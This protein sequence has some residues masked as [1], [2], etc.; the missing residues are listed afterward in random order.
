M[1]RFKS[2]YANFVNGG[3]MI[4][5]ETDYAMR[6]TLYL[7]KKGGESGTVSTAEL[8]EEMAIPYRFLRKIVSKLVAAGLVESRRGKG[9][10]LCLARSATTISLMH[11]IQAVSP[12][13]IV[14]NR[15]V[16]DVAACDRAVYCGIHTELKRMQKNLNEALEGVTLATVSKR[17]NRRSQRS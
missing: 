4:T 6:A 10:G 3:R 1:L 14:L 2:Q 11:I 17:E 5:K 15:C 9:G 12:E 16:V 13:V 7:A 8:S